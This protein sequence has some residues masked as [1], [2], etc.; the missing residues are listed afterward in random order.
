MLPHEKYDE[1]IAILD[2]IYA[3]AEELERNPKPT[4]AFSEK[5]EPRFDFEKLAFERLRD[6]IGNTKIT[7]RE[8]YRLCGLIYSLK[9]VESRQLLKS[10]IERFPVETDYQRVWIRT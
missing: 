7:I 4:S 3:Q 5:I 2:G 8:Y 9:K 6:R 1:W 10:L